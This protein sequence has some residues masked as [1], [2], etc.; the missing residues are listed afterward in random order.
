M[1]PNA[2]YLAKLDRE[3]C[4]LPSGTLRNA[5]FSALKM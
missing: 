5:V 1:E 4:R 2:R 3:D